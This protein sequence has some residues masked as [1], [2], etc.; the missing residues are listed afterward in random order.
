[1]QYFKYAHSDAEDWSSIARALAHG[2]ISGENLTQEPGEALLGVLYVTD[3]I[4]NDMDQIL[5][6]LRQ[7]TGIDE[8]IGTV[9]IGVCST[10][11]EFFDCPAAVAMV[12]RLPE[13]DFFVFST[14]LEK[15]EDL[16]EDALKWIET[17]AP[18]FGIIHCDPNNQRSAK[19]IEDLGGFTSG[20]IVGGF[21]ASRSG[22]QQIAGDITGSGVS[23]ALFTSNIKVAT[24]LSQGCIPVGSAHVV[25]DCLDNVI[26]GLNG[27]NA[28]E[29]FKND[30]GELLAHDLK[31]T[32]GYI[33]AA[34]PIEGSDTGDYIVRNL[35]G[36]DTDRGWL[37]V[38]ENIQAGDRIIFVRRDPKSAEKD[39]IKMLKNLKNRLNKEPRGGIYF[40]CIARGPNLFGDEGK[41]LSIIRKFMGN[42]PLVGF[43]GNGEV[44]NNRVYNYTGVLTLFL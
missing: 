1:M 14:I 18:P 23:G 7:T 13:Q 21:T 28:L 15:I 16:D 4:S 17:N 40:S 19:I 27:K 12:A 24:G 33:H 25:S 8:W 10:E 31:K 22:Q 35:I 38:S 43:F 34:F 41:E 26:F 42:I 30:I 44:S 37:A 3:L 2:L 6:H 32:S 36:I 5:S 11:A 20:F 29:V 39:L 9:G